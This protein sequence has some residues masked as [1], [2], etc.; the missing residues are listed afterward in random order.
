M[1]TPTPPITPKDNAASQLKSDEAYNTRPVAPSDANAV[2]ATNFKVPNEAHP[3][4][5]TST[6]GQQG[7]PKQPLYRHAVRLQAFLQAAVTEIGL[8]NDASSAHGIRLEGFLQM[9]AAEVKVLRSAI[10]DPL[11]DFSLTGEEHQLR[12]HKPI[13]TYVMR[14]EA[15]I[16]GAVAELDHV[17][18]DNPT[19]QSIRL[20]ALVCGA[21]A[22]L[23]ILKGA[24]EA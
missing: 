10:E 11:N 16:N 9:A 20:E 8:N 18:D 22:E 5:A 4:R 14:M 13:R 7:Y 1:P 6:V 17:E 2:G 24:I 23:T 19:P 15:F 21:A 12:T 3:T